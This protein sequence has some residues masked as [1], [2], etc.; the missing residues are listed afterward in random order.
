LNN[1]VGI[2]VGVALLFNTLLFSALPLFVQRHF[3]KDDLKSMNPVNIIQFKRPSPPTPEEEKEKPPEKIR[4]EKVIPTVKLELKKKFIP[5]RPEIE[6]P[7]LSFDLNPALTAGMP[8]SLPPKEAAVFRP[9]ESYIQ[10]EVDQAPIPLVKMKPIYPYR[11]RRLNVSGEVEVKFLVD[12]SGHVD[13]IE[14]LKSKPAGVFDES[15][16]KALQS[17][18]FSPGKVRGHAV[19][20]WVIT[21]IQFDMKRG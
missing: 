3:I 5:P 4:P 12:E 15:V 21:T 10:G 6:T 17:W 18:K 16:I 2:S 19:S 8:V 13:R 9:R 11:A 1:R 14:I 20:T 7:Q